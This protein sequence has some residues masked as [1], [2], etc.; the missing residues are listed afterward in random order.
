MTTKQPEHKNPKKET[1]QKWSSA[2]DPR[3]KKGAGKYPH[4]IVTKTRSGNIPMMIDD[5]P[6]KESMTIQH[7]S[8]SAFQFL[9]D[10]SVQIT[11][12]HGQYNIVFGENRMTVTGAHDLTVKGHGSMMVYGDYNKT[13]HGDVN[14]TVTGGYNITADTHNAVIRKNMDVAVGGNKTTKVAGSESREVQKSMALVAKEDVTLA[15]AKQ[16]LNLGSEKQLSLFTKDQLAM[17]GKSIAAESKQAFDITAGQSMKMKMASLDMKSDGAVKMTGGGNADFN[18]GGVKKM[19]ASQIKMQ[20]GAA[21]ADNAEKPKAPTAMASTN[22][23][24]GGSDTS[25]TST[26]A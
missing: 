23:S 9:P 7:R 6:D 8:G 3:E 12:H 11:S 25:A 15:S 10:G 2:K 22:P 1:P 13:V 21:T 5:T 19:Q 16:S 18:F 17:S 4:Q 24:S 20:E 14:M 26:L